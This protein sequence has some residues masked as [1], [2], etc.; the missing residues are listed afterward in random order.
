MKHYLVS[1]LYALQVKA[2][3]GEYIW[4]SQFDEIEDVYML[5]SGYMRNGFIDAVSTCAFGESI[6]GRQNAAEWIRAAFHDMSTYNETAGTGGLDASA[7]YETEWPQNKGSFLNNT[8]GFFQGFYNTRATASDLLALALVTAT[9]SCSGLKIPYTVGRID[10]TEAGAA[11]VPSPD[12]DLDTHTSIFSRAGF[13][14]ADMITLVAC[15]HTLGGV[16]GEDFPEITGDATV[17]S[18]V[19]FESGDVS[20]YQFDNNVVTEFLDDTT[21]NPLVVGLNETENSDKRIF[22]ADGNVTMQ[23][24]SNTTVFRNE[25]AS[26][27]QRMIETVPA[28]T[29]L[30]TL[31]AI[32]I[33]PYITKMAVNSNGTIDLE[34]QIRVRISAATGRTYSD[35]EMHL[36]YT[37]R[38]GANT[39]ETITTK[40]T[41]S[42]VGTSSGLFQESFGWFQ[43][44]TTI[45]SSSGISAFDIHLTT[46]STGAV[47]SFTNGGTGYPLQDTVLYQPAQSCMNI[48]ETA[49]GMFAVTVTAAVRTD[50]VASGNGT[51]SL[52]LVNRVPQ[53]GVVLPKLQVQS[54]DMEA[55]GQVVG[56]YALYSVDTVLLPS[57]W[58][59]TFDI[60][61]DN[62]QGQSKVEFQRTSDLTLNTCQPL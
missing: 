17:G 46:V 41:D 29:N 26:V 49:D 13:D 58:S 19:F 54:I 53:Q 32:D 18:K 1:G 47:E 28:G 8:F 23:A 57:S 37:D 55:T 11:G 33:K 38:T 60:V 14:T 45:S 40:R 62:G 44:A 50:A 10:A 36:T 61:S 6:P 5:Q 9:S 7:M 2:V 25:C 43:F 48:T 30:T 24:L 35:L 34:G 12:Q 3:L 21:T 22:S 56:D 39:S 59:T 52:D 51:V 4:P 42:D 31:D 27:F 20:Y 15:G 16:H